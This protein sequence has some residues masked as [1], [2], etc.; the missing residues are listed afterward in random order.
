MLRRSIRSFSKLLPS[1]Y[2]TTH[3]IPAFSK[4]SVRSFTKD[5]N[6]GFVSNG[7]Q[8]DTLLDPMRICEMAQA[9]EH[10]SILQEA[11]EHWIWISV[12]QQSLEW[13]HVTTGCPW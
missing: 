10:A 4:D 9:A 7:L 6:Q 13:V 2:E 1:I 5:L 12:V 8:D 11:N 3:S